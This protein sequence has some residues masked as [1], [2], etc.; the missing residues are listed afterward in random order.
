MAA[1]ESA[2]RNAGA[3]VLYFCAEDRLAV[4]AAGDAQRV[5][6]PIGAQPFFAPDSLLEAFA[7]HA[8]LRAQLHRAHNKGIAVDVAAADISELMPWLHRCLEEW[9]ATRG[10]PPLHFLIETD[11]LE[12]LEDRVLLVARRQGTP[13]A[14]AVVTPIPAREGWLIEQ[15]VRGG[16]APNGTA[17]MLLHGVA[18]LA[19]ERGSTTITLG[20]APLAARAPHAVDQ[21]PAWLRTLL[22]GL[23]SHARN[24]Y[25]FEGLENFKAKFRPQHWAPVYA[26]TGPAC[27]LPRALL[28]VA[29]AFSGERL[30]WFVPHTL[31]RALLR[32]ARSKL[33]RG[34]R[35]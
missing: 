6:F 13:V 24:F 16:D 3:R 4:I 30:R 2:A 25:N 17:E 9:Q 26:S 23:R 32:E 11:T 19:R 18:R 15:I 28:A 20:L 7:E 31:G 14:F 27:S 35:G 33:H 12:H 10:L 1:F 5:T 8:S 22:H 29:T 21:S 34:R